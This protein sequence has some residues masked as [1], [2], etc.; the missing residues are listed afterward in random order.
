MPVS[1]KDIQEAFEF[2]SAG[3]AGEHQAFL[4]VQSGKV[5]WHSEFL[6]DLDELPEDIDAPGKYVEIPDKR[7]LNLGKPLVLEFASR[8]LPNDFDE[9]R[10]I[11]SK[12]GAYGRFHA[13]L[14]RRGAREKW[15]DFE[16]KAGEEALRAWCE[17]N[18]IELSE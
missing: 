4:C 11:F 8:F 12:K 15:Y 7:A 13:L 10:R 9:V 6:D 18:S 16:A 14:D 5:Y 1:W 3:L 17:I 2:V